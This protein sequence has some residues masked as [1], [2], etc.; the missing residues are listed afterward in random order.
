MRKTR[1]KLA[2][3]PG[4]ALAHIRAHAGYR[5]ADLGALLDWEQPKISALE[6]GRRLLRFDTFALAAAACG[7]SVALGGV[8]SFFC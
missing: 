1:D 3:R 5:Q 2:M 4:K 7:Y 8:P 6:R